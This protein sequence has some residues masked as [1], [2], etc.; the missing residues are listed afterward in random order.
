[1]RATLSNELVDVINTFGP[2]YFEDF[3]EVTATACMKMIGLT[4]LSVAYPGPFI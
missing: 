2:Q 4:T 3:D 1:M